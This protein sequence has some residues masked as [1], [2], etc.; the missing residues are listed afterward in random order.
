[1]VHTAKD[2]SDDYRQERVYGNI[3]SAELA[4]RQG[5]NSFFDRR[6][7]IVW[8]DD[9]EAANA[10][11]WKTGGSGGGTAAISTE[12]AW[13]GNSS[14][15][16]STA[17]TDTSYQTLSKY[18]SLPMERQMGA[19]VMFHIYAGDPQVLMTLSGYT[20][21]HLN[22]AEVYYD[23]ELGKLYYRDAADN[24]QEL[25][26]VDGYS[27]TLEQWIPMKLVVDWDLGEYL[28]IFFGGTI[29]DMTGIPYFRLASA[30][31]QRVIT[32]LQIATTDDEVATVY[33]DNFIF[34]QNE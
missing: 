6:G 17:G 21:T 27:P 7:N 20:G 5:I 14:M 26:V 3:D 10:Q 2:Y 34:T 12:R 33:F 23:D 11:K 9:F 32:Q 16:V 1:M 25:T 18:Y 22:R 15:K 8:Y 24:W 4:A 13:M 29:Y 31:L 19:E 28:R 30:T